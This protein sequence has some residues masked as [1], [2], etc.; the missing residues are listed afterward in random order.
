[1]SGYLIKR[2]NKRTAG[3]GKGSCGFAY[4]LPVTV[5]TAKIIILLISPVVGTPSFIYTLIYFT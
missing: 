3:Y 4:P 1:M 2:Y 5:H